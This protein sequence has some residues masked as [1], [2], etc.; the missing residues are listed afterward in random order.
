MFFYSIIRLILN[1]INSM[2][3]MCCAF[4]LIIIGPINNW[5]IYRDAVSKP[6]LNLKRV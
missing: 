1:F 6:G 3:C 5:P 2:K 4:T